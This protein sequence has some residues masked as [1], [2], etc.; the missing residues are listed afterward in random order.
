MAE[1]LLLSEPRS[2]L[3]LLEQAI[4]HKTSQDEPKNDCGDLYHGVDPV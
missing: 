4:A 2:M 1:K 3:P